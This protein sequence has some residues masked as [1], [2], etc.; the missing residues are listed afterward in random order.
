[1]ISEMLKRENVIILDRVKDWQQAIYVSL[2]PL[3]RGGYVES[4][5]AEEIIRSTEEI[6]PYYVLTED[7]ALIHGRPEQGGIKTQL[8]VTVVREPVQF[9][10][11]SFPVR[12]LIALAATDANS[13]LDVMKVMSA[14]FLDES[15]I[16]EIAEA[17]SEEKIYNLLLTA[18]KE[19]R[20]EVC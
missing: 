16:R 19:R 11:D 13:H 9:S 18:E 6:G 20:K 8:A 1:M 3:V 14:I 2:E 17:E 5:Y 10:E 4:R 7:I 12:L 15:K